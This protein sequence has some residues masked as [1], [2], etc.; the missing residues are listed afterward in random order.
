MFHGP[1]AAPGMG[2]GDQY[3]AWRPR[4]QRAYKEAKHGS[5]N[6]LIDMES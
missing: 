6:H 3:E 1:P 2:A 5:N 4:P